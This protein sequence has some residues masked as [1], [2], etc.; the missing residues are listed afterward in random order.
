[1]DDH[2]EPELAGDV[3]GLVAGHVVDE[4]DPVDQVVRDV[5]VRPLE[6]PRRVVGG[7][8]DD[9]PRIGSVGHGAKRT[10]DVTG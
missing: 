9:D 7:H 3:D 2:V 6:R 10:G 1:M 5:G 8:D 4:D